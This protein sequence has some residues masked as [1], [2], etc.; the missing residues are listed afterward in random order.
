[1]LAG[2]YSLDVIAVVVGRGQVGARFLAS[3]DSLVEIGVT[4]ALTQSSVSLAPGRPQAVVNAKEVALKS[5]KVGVK[6]GANRWLT[7]K[8]N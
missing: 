5:A 7:C 4:I 2:G 8:N 1:M 6:L 3:P